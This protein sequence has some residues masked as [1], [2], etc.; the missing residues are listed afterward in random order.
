MCFGND[1]PP[2]A[3]HIGAPPPAPEMM[4]II[5]EITGTQSVIVTG[6]DGKKRRV[7]SRLPRT[8]EEEQRFKMAEEL[9]SSSMKNIKQ[10]YQY[11]PQS[12]IDF[13][14]IIETFANINRDRMQSLGQIANIG[15]IEQ[16]VADFKKMQSA[17]I[18]E[19]FQI[20]NA[21][22]EERLAHSGRGSGTYAAESRALMARNEALARQQGDIQASIYGEDL[23]SKRLGRNK[24]AFNLQEMGRQGQLQSA[25]G[26][27]DIAKQHEADMEKRR[28]MAIEENKGLLNIG[29][30]IIGQD[31]NK[32]MANDNAGISLNTFNAQA[33]DSM[34]RYNA[35]VKRQMANY[36]MA[37]NEYNSRGPSM[38]E[39]L[40]RT[41]AQVG[42]A[43]YGGGGSMPFGSSGSNRVGSDTVG[44][45]YRG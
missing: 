4:D 36:D 20:K 2:A 5:D 30:G 21:E 39:S 41:G 24:E 17:L 11:N 23:A 32:A 10:L 31:L 37:M 7:N 26:Q 12:M 45:M 27:Y 29:S 28:L 8:P 14:P 42:G 1:D 22:N 6:A 19:Q 38:M 18:D 43:I 33:N 44:R 34:N 35:D 40:L 25:Q 16:D 3:P 15:N 9:I 13:A